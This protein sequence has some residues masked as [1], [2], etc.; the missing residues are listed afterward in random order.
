MSAKEIDK[1]SYEHYVSEQLESAATERRYTIVKKL[2]EKLP[3][4]E[5]TVVTLHY[6]GEM[7]TKEI[8]KFLGVS[9][10]TIH[11]RLHRARKRLHGEEELLVHEVLG[12]VQLPANLAEQ[13]MRQVADLK[14]IPAP[15]TKP[16]LPWLA[17]GTAVILI[18]LILGA[19]NQYL[20][21]F[22][23]PYSFEAQSEHTIEIIDAPVVLDIDSKPDVRN[24]AGRDAPSSQNGNAGSQTSE[25]LLTSTA[26]ENSVTHEKNIELC[27]QNLIAIGNAIHS[28]QNEHDDFP[29][30]LSDLHPKYLA[31][32]HV[33]I[34]PADTEDG[35]A[36]LHVN[37]DPKMSMSY[38]YQFHPEY[39]AWK[40]EQR[41]VYG[42]V[43][44]LVRCR[45]HANED[46]YALNLS[47]SSQIYRSSM[48][49]EYTPEDMYSS[50]EAAITAFEDTLA[51]Y[52][53][54]PRFFDLHPLLVNLY[55]KVGNEQ[56]AGALIERLKSG[57]IPDIQGYRT[58][59][60]IFDRIERYEDML[61]I[62]KVAEQLHP[63]EQ[64]ILAR[65]TFIYKKLGNIE[66]AEAYER[67]FDPTYE[68]FGKPVPD[69]SATDLDGNSISL[70]NYH[71]K[72]VLLDFWA[73]W[74][75]FS[76]EEM[77]DIKKVYDTYKDEGFDIVG[78]NLDD[79]EAILRGYIKENDIHW[80][81]VFDTAA[82]E[83]SLVQQYGINGVPEL[84]L[85]DREGK[86]ITH[87]ARGE[88]L[89]KHVAA[90]VKAQSQD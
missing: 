22:Q 85:I 53:D 43:M 77:P 44:P 69:F 40:N 65:L 1:L 60:D 71:G 28:Y 58:L 38:D 67:K 41:L 68:L 72:V 4:S 83:D 26:G 46:F 19:S 31:D 56:S 5:R 36:D 34:C 84:W 64:P 51:R 52:P 7:T 75:G 86:L 14:P 16:L 61:E 45:H 3:E 30:W 66:L 80:R 20:L 87:K 78:V 25:T 89:E 37:I 33:L 21:H 9:V 73:V 90:A 48:N 70:Q 24:Q 10:N 35:K 82:G 12:S 88:N 55:T 18:A 42:D 57:M 6:L 17:L 11:S 39:R 81:Q 13:I 29:E 63:D 59:Y 8:G 32:A 79:E 2:L 76:V 49:W 23:Q 15:T 62:F 27:T 47:F 54:D 74:C 50:H